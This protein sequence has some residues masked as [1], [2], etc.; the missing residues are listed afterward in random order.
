MK[1][2]VT[3]VDNAPPELEGQ[4]PFDAELL[5]M[6][7]GRDRPDYWIA[8]LAKPIRWLNQGRES[9]VTHIILVARLQGTQIGPG[10]RPM[11]VG[12]AY[13][14]DSSVLGDSSLDFK[15]CAYVA[16]GTAEELRPTN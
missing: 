13:I 5:K 6:I 4:T 15:K 16:I 8:V 10:M 11:P 7:P 3:S 9:E 12:I 1:I 2:R 14:V